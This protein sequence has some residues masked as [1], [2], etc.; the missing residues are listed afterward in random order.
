[1]DIKK[2]IDYVNTKGNIIEKARLAV[3]LWNKKPKLDV[4]QKLGSLQ[5]T[6]GGFSYWVKNISNICDTC[7]ILEWFDDLKIHHSPIVDSACRFLL[8]RQLRDGC[9]YDVNV[10]IDLNPPEWMIPGRFDTRV[11]LSGYFAHVLIRFVY[12]EEVCTY[13]PTDFLL[14]NCD[15]TGRMKGYLRA[16]WLALPML[17]FYPGPD[18]KI[19]NKAV[20][21][22]EDNYSPD[23]KGSYVAWL[24]RCLKDAKLVVLHPLV[25]R[26]L[27][28]LRRKQDRD[29]SWDPEEGEGEEH[30]VNATISS[31]RALKD[32]EQI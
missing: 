21:V 23:W 2:A 29:G 7:Y 24:L 5:K 4:L 8:D 6:D 1:M 15:N 17:A 16:T 32:Y 10:I 9:C 27:S 31:L 26:S 13:C 18:P 22:V 3:I 30:R 28:Q 11:W 20:K 25:A 14:A 12:A 19:F